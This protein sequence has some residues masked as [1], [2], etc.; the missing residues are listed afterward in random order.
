MFFLPSKDIQLISRHVS[1]RKVL[2]LLHYALSL[3]LDMRNMGSWSQHEAFLYTLAKWV[4][5]TSG[6]GQMIT[7]DRN[8]IAT[9]LESQA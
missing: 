9:N 2:P 7:L 3:A 8:E 1:Y 5:N 6:V 4:T